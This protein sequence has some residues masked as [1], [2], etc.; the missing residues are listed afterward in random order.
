MCV[1]C[2]DVLGPVLLEVG[3][4]VG[5]GWMGWMLQAD[6]DGSL[7]DV[8]RLVDKA[9]QVSVLHTDGG[10]THCDWQRTNEAVLQWKE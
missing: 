10:Q 1:Q 2:G 7:L 5:S 4:L 8:I 3:W 6:G 9:W